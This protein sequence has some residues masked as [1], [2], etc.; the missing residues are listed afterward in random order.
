MFDIF[1]SFLI[2]GHDVHVLDMSVFHMGDS[3]FDV[4]G[5]WTR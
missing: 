1:G 3:R 4:H 5:C 2:D